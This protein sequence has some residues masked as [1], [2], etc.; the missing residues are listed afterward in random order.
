MRKYTQVEVAGLA[1]VS[2]SSIKGT[3]ISCSLMS[4][5]WS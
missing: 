1:G 4:F 2:P 3:S 5:Q